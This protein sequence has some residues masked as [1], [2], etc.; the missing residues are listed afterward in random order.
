VA[1][2][3]VHR[4]HLSRGLEP[5]DLVAGVVRL[6]D[7]GEADVRDVLTG[8]RVASGWQAWQVTVVEGSFECSIAGI[9]R[10]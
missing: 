1:V 2:S 4:P 10:G 7:L 6:P 8:L 5:L 9:G 3:A